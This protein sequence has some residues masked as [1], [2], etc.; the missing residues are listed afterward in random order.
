MTDCGA[1]CCSDLTADGDVRCEEEKKKP[2]EQVKSADDFKSGNEKGGRNVAASAATTRLISQL[3]ARA[4]RIVSAR[5]D[6]GNTWIKLF[7]RLPTNCAVLRVAL[8]FNY[9]RQEVAACQFG[10]GARRS[11]AFN[12]KRDVLRLLSILTRPHPP[13][14]H[15]PSSATMAPSSCSPPLLYLRLPPPSRPALLLSA[16]TPSAPPPFTFRLPL[17]PS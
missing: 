8:S 2:N 17:P 4:N 15:L 1:P 6:P 12:S 5:H 16:R 11:V 13:R 9:R 3:S 10:A 7:T 14:P